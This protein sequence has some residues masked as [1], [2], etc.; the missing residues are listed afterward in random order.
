MP[1]E[2]LRKS[3]DTLI[4]SEYSKDWT[5]KSPN[6][7]LNAIN[8]ILND[9]RIQNIKKIKELKVK[10]KNRE[11][12]SLQKTVWVPFN[13]CDW[14]LWPESLSYLKNYINKLAKENHISMQ[15]NSNLSN[16]QWNIQNVTDT[17]NI[18]HNEAQYLASH[19]TM[20]QIE[21][22]RLFSWKE[23]LQQWQLGDCYLV[24]WIH[25]LANAQHFDTLMRTSIQRV[26]RNG[27]SW[28]R[29][30]QIKIPLWEPTGRKIYLKDSE[31]RIAR[32]RWNI[33][34][35]LLELAYAKNKLRKN[36]KNWNR[37]TPITPSELQKIEWWWTHEV[38]TTFLGKQNIWFNDFWTMKNYRE[39]KRLS[40][41]SST[42]KTEI[43]N[44]LKHYNPKIWNKFVSLASL[45]GSSDKKS[46]N[47]WWKI[48][49]HRHAY[50]LSWV[51]KDGAWNIISIRVL[52]PWNAQW[53]W[54]NYQDFT[55]SE[56][57]NSFSA[58]SC[59]KIKARTF[60][61]NKSV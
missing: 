45:K 52:N 57:F 14:K 31:I 34:Y 46:Y 9:K 48:L 16:L 17:I 53:V 20:S 55:P 12:R 22:N 26:Q 40:V 2:V 41:S 35:K 56:F 11:Y 33:W 49:Y 61:D 47:V 19:E 5:E 50:S 27:W 8:S 25:E 10:I 30:Y 29:G 3:N 13:R 32:I 21:Y 44:F 37:Y 43:T 59:G 42:A 58:M 39:G 60:L 18:Q 38:L 15:T 6:S 4:T 54:K 1:T 7:K 36:D 24:S 51:N 23:R 28:E